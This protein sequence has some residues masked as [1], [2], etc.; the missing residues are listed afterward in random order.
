MKAAFSHWAFRRAAASRPEEQGDRC[1]SGGGSRRQEVGAQQR[2]RD[3]H[4]ADQQVLPGG[5][6]RAAMAV[7]V[8]QGSA[9]QG[10]GLHG[11]PHQPEVLA[12]GDQ[13]HRRLEAQQPGGEMRLRGRPARSA[14]AS[15]ARAGGPGLPAAQEG[16]GVHGDP[17]EQRAAH[18]QE[19]QAQRVHRQPLAHGGEAPAVGPGP[20]H[21]A[22]VGRGGGR[23]Q[24]RRGAAEDQAGQGGGGGQDDQ[25]QDHRRQSF[26]LASWSESM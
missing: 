10:G 13:A 25:S 24:A 22:Q 23:Q 12:H 15:A 21:Q 4:R 3:A 19:Q 20:G 17:Q 6:Q 5:L 11:H 18:R 16:D 8:D 9:Q 26:K 1:R 14:A 2:H 7:I